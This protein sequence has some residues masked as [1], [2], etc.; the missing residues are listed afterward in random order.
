MEDRDFYGLTM[1]LGALAL[2]S[3]LHSRLIRQLYRDQ[4][5][6]MADVAFMMDRPPVSHETE[7]PR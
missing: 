3:I 6:V 7:D 2:V 4:V 5:K 1:V